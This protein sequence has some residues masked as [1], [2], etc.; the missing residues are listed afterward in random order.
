[1]EGGGEFVVSTTRPE[2]LGA[3]VAV[4]AHPGDERYKHLLGKRARTPLFHALVPILPSEHA[5][6]EK[7][8]GILMVCTFGD[9]ADVEFW[10]GRQLPLRQLIGLDGRM[11][12]VRFGESPFE[13]ADPERARGAWAELEGKTV[14]Q[15]QAKSV[16]LLRAAG[17]LAAEPRAITHAV[18]FYE[19]GTRPLEFVPTRQWFVRVLDHRRELHRAGTQDRVAAVVH[20]RPLRELGRGPEPG[21]V[22]EPPALLR[23]A[24]PGLVSARCRRRAR[25]RPADLGR[26]REPADRSARHSTAPATP[27]RSG[28]SPAASRAT[29]T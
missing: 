15:A 17:A 4:V 13:S 1:M 12:A 2:L 20:A 9:Q 5:D 8:T 24:V 25:L 10:K 22:R 18:K 6:P 19:R 21:L 27:R 23:R 26:A 3:C 28:A 16:E 14:K 29:P 7:G 11:R